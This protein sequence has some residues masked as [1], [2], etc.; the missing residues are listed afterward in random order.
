MLQHY[1][2]RTLSGSFFKCAMYCTSFFRSSTS[3]SY[4]KTSVKLNFLQNIFFLAFYRTKL[5]LAFS[6][7][8]NSRSFFM[9]SHLYHQLTLFFLLINSS[10]LPV[11]KEMLLQ[12]LNRI[13]IQEVEKKKEKVENLHYFSKNKKQFSQAG[14]LSGKK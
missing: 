14:I 10:S 3:K 9:Q 11:Q 13:M 4:K 2:E 5:E 12:A 6:S 8:L 1:Y 7:N